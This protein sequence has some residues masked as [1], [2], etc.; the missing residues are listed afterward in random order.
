MSYNFNSPIYIIINNVRRAAYE[1][2][3]IRFLCAGLSLM[4]SSAFLFPLSPCA[5][6]CR[7]GQ[8]QPPQERPNFSIPQK[9]TATVTCLAQTSPLRVS[10]RSSSY[11]S[12]YCRILRMIAGYSG[13]V[14]GSMSSNRFDLPFTN[15]SA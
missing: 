6:S 3:T 11:H 13:I 1:S 14:S 2:I 8:V 15:W 4:S 12:R 9:I 7:Q 10:A 5:G